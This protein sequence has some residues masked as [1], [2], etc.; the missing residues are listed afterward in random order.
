[1]SKVIKTDVSLLE[2]K[3]ASRLFGIIGKNMFINNDKSSACYHIRKR[4]I[5]ILLFFSSVIWILGWTPYTIVAF[6]QLIG[7]GQEVSQ[8]FSV[9]G[10]LSCK[11]SSVLNAYIYGMRYDPDTVMSFP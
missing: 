7:K 1:M 9:F 11:S 4:R 2:R 10:L 8:Y 6:L 5:L 3:L